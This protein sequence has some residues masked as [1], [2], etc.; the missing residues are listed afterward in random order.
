MIS[1]EFK[2]DGAVHKLET[3][4]SSAEDL[5]EPLHV[6]GR[7][8]VLHSRAAFDAQS[9][10]PLAPSTVAKRARAGVRKAEKSLQRD[11][12][13][14]TVKAR[15]SVTP[16]GLQRIFGVPSALRDAAAASSRSVQRSRAMLGELRRQHGIKDDLKSA[17]SG[18][19]LTVAQLARVGEKAKKAAEKEVAKPILGRLR[20]SLGAKVSGD[21]VTV[22]EGT[23]THWSSVHNS[24]GTAGHGA[25]IP[26]RTTLEL[27]NDDVEVFKQMLTDHLLADWE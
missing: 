27:T 24:G 23:V 4:A 9:F 15:A 14:A 12:A 18:S 2:V 6:F 1:I 10:E 13:R 17:A 5:P 19:G 16:R 22:R 3:L 25:R 7:Y 8:K 11:V 20:N 26:Q 21:S